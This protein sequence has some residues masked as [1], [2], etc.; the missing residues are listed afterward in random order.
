MKTYEMRFRINE[1]LYKK[2]K[3]LCI[4]KNLSIPKQSVELIRKFVEI[5]EK[6]EKLIKGN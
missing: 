4:Q 3:I 5:A 2:Y 6:N 1:D